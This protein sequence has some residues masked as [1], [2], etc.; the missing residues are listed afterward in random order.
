MD[1]E[2]LQGIA[3]AGVEMILESWVDEYDSWDML[4]ADEGL[5]DEEQEYILNNLTFNVQAKLL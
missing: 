2:K 1:I 4:F 5:T 3:Q